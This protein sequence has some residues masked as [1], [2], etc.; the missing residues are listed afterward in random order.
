MHSRTGLAVDGLGHEGNRLAF[1]Y[2][3][4][5]DDVLGEHRLVCHLRHWSELDLD[6]HLSGAADLMVMVT[7]L[8]ALLLH[9]HGH[10]A[11]VVVIDILRRSDVITALM[12]CLIAEAA[13]F[14]A[15]PERFRTVHGK[16]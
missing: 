11:S 8:D 4:V 16:A 7:D 3:L 6:L 13:V 15:V 1:P 14:A 5:L 9:Q 2:G 10:A 12:R